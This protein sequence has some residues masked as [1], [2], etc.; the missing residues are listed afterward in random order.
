ME[1][2]SVDR[3]GLATPASNIS[4][5]RASIRTFNGAIQVARWRR[6]RERNGHMAWHLFWM[7]TCMSFQERAAQDFHS[8][9]AADIP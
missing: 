7:G 8:L 6:R 5:A 9:S 4:T 3:L 2:S 1:P